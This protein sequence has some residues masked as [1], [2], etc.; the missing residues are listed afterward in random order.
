M[1]LT[2]Y[3]VS[4]GG[5][6]TARCPVLAGIAAKADCS[7]GTLYMIAGGHKSPSAKL[8]VRISDACGG[9]VSKESLRP[10]IFGAPQAA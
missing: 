2:E 7:P 3:I 5:T 4:Q 9:A 8:A 1:N 10:D 6:A